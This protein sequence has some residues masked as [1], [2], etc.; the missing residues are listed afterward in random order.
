MTGR[1]GSI[2]SPQ[3]PLLVSLP[4]QES[5][6]SSVPAELLVAR[7]QGTSS[8]QFKKKKKKIPDSTTLRPQSENTVPVQP[9]VKRLLPAQAQVMPALPLILFGSMAL[10]AGL[11][12][13]IFPETLGTKL[14][15]T[16]REAENIGKPQTKED[17]QDSPS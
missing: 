15:D 13:L 10:A 12:S 17:V 7:V 3:T 14:P 11:L 6:F 1:M 16:V 2:L 9:F 8:G 5:T 4:P